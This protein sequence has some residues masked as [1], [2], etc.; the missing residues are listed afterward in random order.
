VARI[1]VN[2]CCALAAGTAGKSQLL[3][4]FKAVRVIGLTDGCP[5]LI[6]TR[7]A[8]ANDA[9]GPMEQSFFQS[10]LVLIY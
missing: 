3:L 6:D 9:P 5:D 4:M 7:R 1:S 8:S 2:L 10:P